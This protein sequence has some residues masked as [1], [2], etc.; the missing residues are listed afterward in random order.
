MTND[1]KTMFLTFSQGFSM[2]KE[3][4][5]QLFTAMFGE[6]SVHAICI[7]EAEIENEQPLFVTI[8]SW[9]PW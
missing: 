2:S 5:V 3:E 4:V 9:T 7:G 8:W 6:M 1:D